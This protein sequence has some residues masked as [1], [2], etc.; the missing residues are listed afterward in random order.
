[1]DDTRGMSD[2]DRAL[3]IQ[4]LL[5]HEA[6]FK[7]IDRELRSIRGYLM[8]IDEMREQLYEWLRLMRRLRR[9]DDRRERDPRDNL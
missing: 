1:M 5:D 4:M 8:D 9:M 3:A 7:L 6:R 2:L